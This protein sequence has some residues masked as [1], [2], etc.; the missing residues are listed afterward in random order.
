M[1]EYLQTVG[2]GGWYSKA[3]PEVR[4]PGTGEIQR[5][6]TLS[7]GEQQ[8]LATGRALMLEPE[9]LTKKLVVHMRRFVTALND[10][11]SL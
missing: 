9:L 1:Q 11:E 4:E 7:S 5:T 10:Q 6:G 3:D 8:M 2:N